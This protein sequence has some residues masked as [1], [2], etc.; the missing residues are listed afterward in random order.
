MD[1][2]ANF[3]EK[4]AYIYT[5]QL[6]VC[7]KIRGQRFY[8]S[9]FSEDYYCSCTSLAFDCVGLS[10]LFLERLHCCRLIR[11]V[12]GGSV[13]LTASACALFVAF[14]P[15]LVTLTIGLFT[16][17]SLTSAAVSV[18]FFIFRQFGLK[19]HRIPLHNTRFHRV[20]LCNVCLSILATSAIAL[21]CAHLARC[22]A[23]A[24]HLQ[25][26]SLS[27]IAFHS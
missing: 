10:C 13:V 9:I 22:K 24:I 25:A 1:K 23:V 16:A 27:T 8:Q 18:L 15:Q 11:V 12:R 6:S 26:Q 2:Y 20:D 17:R 19:R 21:A 3:I 7:L 14:N 5:L 4:T